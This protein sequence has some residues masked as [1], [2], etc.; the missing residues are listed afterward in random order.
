MRQSVH[1]REEQMKNRPRNTLVKA[2]QSGMSS[3]TLA[4]GD[5]MRKT[6]SV[7]NISQLFLSP[8]SGSSVSMLGSN[9]K[10]IQENGNS[11]AS[12]G[13]SPGTGNLILGMGDGLSGGFRRSKP[14]RSE[15]LSNLSG[16]KSPPGSSLTSPSS[17]QSP[18][19]S[20]PSSL[21]LGKPGIKVCLCTWLATCM[22]VLLFLIVI[23]AGHPGTIT[24]PNTN[25]PHG[26]KWTTMMTT[27]MEEDSSGYG[28]K[29]SEDSPT[30]TG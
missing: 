4:V 24:P 15:S 26:S 1:L 25:T 14:I 10:M 20:R 29:S 9:S 22:R 8:S 19:Q 6:L 17:G 11:S 12:N 30:T 3:S 16:F 7:P 5:F 18:Q 2:Q 23:F 21:N 13:Q 27:V 28:S